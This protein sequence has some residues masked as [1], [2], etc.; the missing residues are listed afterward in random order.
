MLDVIVVSATD[1]RAISNEIGED[2]RSRWDVAGAV[3]AL[4]GVRPRL[5][6][7]IAAPA[8]RP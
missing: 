3:A 6:D 5:L 7:A 4:H 2:D 1:L 8:R